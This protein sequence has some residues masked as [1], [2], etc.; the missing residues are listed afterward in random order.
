MLYDHQTG[1]LWSQILSEAVTGPKTGTALKTF[2]LIETTWKDWK[3]QYP[4]TLVLSLKTGYLRPYHEDPYGIRAERALGVIAGG[5]TKAYSLDQLKKVKTFPLRDRVGEQRVLIHFRKGTQRA[6]A[7][8]AEGEPV[9]F[10]LT[11]SACLGEF[12]SGLGNL[13]GPI[14]DGK[15]ERPQAVSFAQGPAGPLSFA[16]LT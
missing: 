9:E 15:W 5:K 4:E 11:Y 6:W 14:V 1:S 10:F 16:S 8:D 13:Q 2:P 7:T 12:L 3:E